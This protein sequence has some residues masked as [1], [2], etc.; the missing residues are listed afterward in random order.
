MVSES[1]VLSV[2]FVTSVE[3][4]V[5]LGDLQRQGKLDVIECIKKGLSET[6]IRTGSSQPML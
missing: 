5:Q 3:M 1:Y 6:G 2:V 4:A